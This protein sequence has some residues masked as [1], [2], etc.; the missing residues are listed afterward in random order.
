[1][2]IMIFR[3]TKYILLKNIIYIIKRLFLAYL[4]I[5]KKNYN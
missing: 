3:E 5:A 2:T 4:S 1:M